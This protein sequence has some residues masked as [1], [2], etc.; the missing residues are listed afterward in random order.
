MRYFSK[1]QTKV[2]FF[3]LGTCNGFYMNIH[4]HNKLQLNCV[5]IFNSTLNCFSSTF[6]NN[7]YS[8]NFS[9]AKSTPCSKYSKDCSF[10]KKYHTFNYHLPQDVFC[11][12]VLFASDEV[13]HSGNQNIE[14]TKSLIENF[15]FL[16]R[17]VMLVP[18]NT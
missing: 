5:T 18:E 3:R 6:G 4:D 9:I 11:W 12:K 17:F 16:L 15:Q 10:H 8:E 2:I 1:E 13:F 7:M 14:N